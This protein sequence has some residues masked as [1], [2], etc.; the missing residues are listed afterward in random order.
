MV[1]PLANPPMGGDGVKRT[2]IL[3]LD[4]LQ[5]K[6]RGHET[7]FISKL[8]YWTRNETHRMIF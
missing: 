2:L 5:I 4:L 3:L 8:S 6:A 1:L 7:R